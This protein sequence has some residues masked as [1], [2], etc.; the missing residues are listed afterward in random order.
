MPRAESTGAGATGSRGLQLNSTY[1]IMLMK[2]YV[3]KIRTSEARIYVIKT[4]VS[5]QW[6]STVKYFILDLFLDV[7]A[8]GDNKKQTAF[9]IDS[10]HVQ[11]RPPCSLS[12]AWGAVPPRSPRPREV[13]SC[14]KGSC[15]P[16]LALG[17]PR[18]PCGWSLCLIC[19]AHP[20]GIRSTG[21]SP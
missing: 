7:L 9:I 20:V 1:D 16:G 2:R 17:P 19:W 15:S 6:L 10:N 12:G 18:G 14:E 3:V 11:A 13:A 5:Q 21:S 4:T 8:H